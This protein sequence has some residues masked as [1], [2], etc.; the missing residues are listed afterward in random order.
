MGVA[1]GF[2]ILSYYSVIAGWTI[3]YFISSFTGLI[4]NNLDATNYFNEFVANGPQVVLFQAIFMAITIYV[5]Y[6]GVEKGIETWS[7]LLMPTLVIIILLLIIRAISLPGASAGINFYLN[8]DF[9][10]ISGKT[11]LAALGQA[12]FSLSLGMGAMIT[13]GSYIPKNISLPKSAF[14]V[15]LL[16]MLIAFLAGFV[17]FPI[18]FTFGIEPS[19]GPGLIFVSLPSVFGL[20]PIGQIWSALFFLLLFIAALTSAIGLLEVV[21]AYLIDEKKWSR[22]KASSVFGLAIFVLGIPSALSNGAFN[23]NLFGM[24]F[25]DAMDFLASNIL[26]PIGGIFITLFVGWTIKKVALRE[27]NLEGQFRLEKIW[28]G[29]CRIIAPIFILLIFLAGIG[30][31]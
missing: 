4:S 17:I 14:T 2:I 6:L 23:L 18:V 11:V 26:L 1:A 31:F 7:K 28:I 10:E 12:F 20:M 19:A 8:P 25:L 24:N 30:L 29:I 22:K 16:D 3:K 5:V 27:I 21:V 9:S 13:Y 15:T